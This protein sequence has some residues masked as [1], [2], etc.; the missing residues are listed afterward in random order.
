M[1]SHGNPYASGIPSAAGVLFVLRGGII[2]AYCKA[3]VQD[4]P[5]RLIELM[6]RRPNQGPILLDLLAEQKAFLEE[7]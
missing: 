5:A 1:Q 7:A 2:P 3:F 4:L 6:C